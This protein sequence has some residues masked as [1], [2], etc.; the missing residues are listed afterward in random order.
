[1]CLFAL[2]LIVT[3]L[4]LGVYYLYNPAPI[5]IV[6][7]GHHLVAAPGWAPVALGA[8]VPLALFFLHAISARIRI[9]LLRRELYWEDEPVPVVWQIDEPSAAHPGP[10]RRARASRRPVSPQPAPKRSWMTHRD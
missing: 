7:P 9:W 1:M 2:A 6:M 10:P 8:A 3:L 5:D 4:G